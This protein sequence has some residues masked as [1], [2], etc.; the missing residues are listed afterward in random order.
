M[1]VLPGETVMCPLT[2]LLAS[3]GMTE[4]LWDAK[5]RT[6]DAVLCLPTSP[7]LTEL[8]PNLQVHPQC[9]ACI[10]GEAFLPQH[11]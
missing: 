9:Q 4:L 10:N 7:R 11:Y 3:W 6:M 8:T 5:L 1:S 2:Q